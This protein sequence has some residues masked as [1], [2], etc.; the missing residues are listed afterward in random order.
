MFGGK[1]GFREGQNYRVFENFINKMKRIIDAI[2][3][4]P[5][6]SHLSLS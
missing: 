1:L 4:C 6:P 5:E 2:L 3:L